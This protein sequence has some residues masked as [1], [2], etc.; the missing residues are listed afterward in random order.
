[1]AILS[2][3]DFHLRNNCDDSAD[4][5]MMMVI[6]MLDVDRKQLK[7]AVWAFIHLGISCSLELTIQQVCF[8]ILLKHFVLLSYKR[9]QAPHNIQGVSKKVAPIKL[10]E[11]LHFG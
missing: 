11:Y 9:F 8:I 5:M 7:S 2:C 10:F 4:E 6:M 3:N 1:M